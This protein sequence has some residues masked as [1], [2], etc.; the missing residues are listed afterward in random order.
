MANLYQHQLLASFENLIHLDL[1]DTP[2]DESGAGEE[3]RVDINRLVGSL[4]H[5]DRILTLKLP[6]SC[7]T[8]DISFAALNSPRKLIVPFDSIDHVQFAR[9]FSM[10]RPS[11]Q[12]LIIPSAQLTTINCVIELL[13]EKLLE[14]KMRQR[15][16]EGDEV[17]STSPSEL[18]NLTFGKRDALEEVKLYFNR[19]FTTECL[20]LFQKGVLHADLWA[21]A[22]T[23]GVKLTVD[24]D[25]TYNGKD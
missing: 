19:S 15:I 10:L 16:R 12:Q 5:P 1:S 11:L 21:K 7:C 20:K 17:I 8:R 24:Q 3:S 2:R 25:Y 4:S 6:R 14:Q 22:H 13:D 18:P 9:F 23:A